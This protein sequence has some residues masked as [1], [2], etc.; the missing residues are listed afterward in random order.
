MSRELISA[1][2]ELES[3]GLDF[4]LEEPMKR[5]ASWHKATVAALLAVATAGLASGCA[6]KNYVR[7]EV[8]TTAQ[9]L[10]ARIENT[11]HGIEALSN[12]T[13]ELNS[14]NREH[15]RQ[16]DSLDSNL[17][18]V[19]ERAG[20]AMAVGEGA[21]HAAELNATQVLILGENFANRNQYRLLSEE[22]VRFAFDSA[23]IEPS[24]HQLLDG[25]AR[26]MLER[27]DAILV[28]EGRTDSSGND[29]YNI[30]LGE[31]RLEAVIRHLVVDQGVSIHRL[32]KMSFGE[33]RPLAP[34][35]SRE[36]RAQN[37]SVVIQ[38]LEPQ[39]GNPPEV[40]QDE[41]QDE[42]RAAFIDEIISERRPD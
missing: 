2:Y 4:R 28:L 34:N 35:G 42:N 31:R 29:S 16:I 39:L 14:L 33:A 24:Y 11:E 26:R 18:Q 20:Y 6:T 27:P 12:Q 15:A 1:C 3:P 40:S 8:T 30:R 21:Q 36:G 23:S 41:I 32:Y 19:D 7:K 22:Y 9:G 37:R 13:E 17:Q 10:S 25:M 38:I 5:K